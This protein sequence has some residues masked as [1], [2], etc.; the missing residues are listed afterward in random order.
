LIGTVSY[1]HN[2]TTNN[3]ILIF[4]PNLGPLEPNGTHAGEDENIQTGV[5][6][7]PGYD[8]DITWRIT[9]DLNLLVGFSDVNS[10]QPNGN[11]YRNGQIGFNYKALAR[12]SFSRANSPIK[13]LRGLSVGAG[14]LNV[15][16]RY[17]SNG[18]GYTLAGGQYIV[19][20]YNELDAFA[21][22]LIGD[23]WRLQVNGNNVANE[24]G[25]ISALGDLA[26][27]YSL[28]PDNF[29]FTVKYSF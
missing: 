15:A 21:T 2:E 25:I 13:A 14:L 10:V 19:P 4:N 11:G 8:G 27:N 3:P 28:P 1:F 24:K 29:D 20:G 12:Y 22:Y 26:Y 23:H 6:K 5:A 9:D 16:K 7:F 17:G 18:L